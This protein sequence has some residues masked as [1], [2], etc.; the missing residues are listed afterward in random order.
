M[1]LAQYDVNLR[2]YWRIIRKRKFIVL[3]IAVILGVFSTVFAILSAPAPLYSTE[4]MIEIKRERLVEGIYS[5]A[6]AWDD[7]DDIETQIAVIK[8]YTVFEKVAEHMGLIPRG[9]SSK[10]ENQLKSHVIATIEGLQS[11][12]EVTRLKY[13]SILTL[14]VTDNGAAFA[15]R[16]A[17]TVALVYRELHGGA[18]EQ[19][20]QGGAAL[21]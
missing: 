10:G 15:Q 19:A 12:V 3:V 7:S 11:K 6:I 4:C 14:K 9:S 18:A 2:E 13:S 16:L 1:P 8:S 5:K 20:D 17:N 21:H